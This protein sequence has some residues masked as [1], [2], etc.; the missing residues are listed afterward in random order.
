LNNNPF[1]SFN[2][3]VDLFF[4]LSVHENSHFP[5]PGKSKKTWESDMMIGTSCHESLLLL[6][7]LLCSYQIFRFQTV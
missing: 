4:H 5:L 1:F 3:I 2:L 6:V 7:V